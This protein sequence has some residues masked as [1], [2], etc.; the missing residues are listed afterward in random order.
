MSIIFFSLFFSRIKGIIII[1]I[2]KKLENSAFTDPI[3]R[4]NSEDMTV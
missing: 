2:D 4:L 1:T 3:G